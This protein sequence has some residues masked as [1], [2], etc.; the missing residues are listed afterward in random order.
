MSTVPIHMSTACG[1]LFYLFQAQKHE[2]IQSDED[3]YKNDSL[4]VPENGRLRPAEDR[5]G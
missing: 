1:A 3:M 2:D 5:I 4:L